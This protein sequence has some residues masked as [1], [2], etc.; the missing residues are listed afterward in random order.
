MATVKVKVPENME[1][2]M[3]Q[4]RKLMNGADIDVVREKY[5]RM[6]EGLLTFYSFD[7]QSLLRGATV[8]NQ[9]K[10]IIDNLAEKFAEITR[11]IKT[12]REESDIKDEDEMIATY[13]DLCTHSYVANVMKT[14]NNFKID[15]VVDFLTPIKQGSDT[16]FNGFVG[17]FKPLYFDGIQHQF[18]FTY[19]RDTFCVG[20]T[21]R[22]IKR[23]FTI[24]YAFF[25]RLY[26]GMVEV[27]D[28]L[29]SPDI[30]PREFTAALIGGLLNMRRQSPELDRCGDA[31]KLIEVN[32]KLL[33]KNFNTYYRDYKKS[34]GKDISSFIINFITDIGKTKANDSG[35]T[36][37]TLM[38]QFKKIQNFITNA[39]PRMK[40]SGIDMDGLTRSL[41]A[42]M[43]RAE[44][45]VKEMEKKSGTSESVVED[46]EKMSIVS[47]SE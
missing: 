40:A 10:K 26:D 5:V 15:N 6:V 46:I 23:D 8:K 32:A 9:N 3:L 29:N 39:A 30:D 35:K 2:V 11:D 24:L 20:D 12:F 31:F 7:I 22:G 25:K 14:Y 37:V 17:D 13:R 41:N 18:N 1:S 28:L 16:F 4:A 44:K 27:D 38:A 47:P 43:E 45:K 19:I 42:Q 36:P 33:E 34:G 21:G